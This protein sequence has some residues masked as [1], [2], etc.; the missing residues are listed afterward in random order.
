MEV[1]LNDESL[2]GQYTE[3]EFIEFCKN[4]L[5]PILSELDQYGMTLLKAYS[6]YSKMITSSESVRSILQ[7]RGNPVLDR[8]KCYLVQLT[9]DPFW[10][11]SIKTDLTLKYEGCISDVPN[12]FTEAYARD[13]LLLSFSDERFLEKWLDIICDEKVSKIRNIG[14]YDSCCFHLSELGYIVIWEKNSFF[15]KDIGY[16]FEVRFNEGHHNIAHFHLSN[17][18]E[19]Q[20]LISNSHLE[21]IINAIYLGIINFLQIK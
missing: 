12:C 8:M 4:D 9:K 20:L 13:G 18:D 14:T 19:E 17:A 7:I 3:E 1:L 2:N 11:N 15:I 6:T 21:K 16:K 5:L 10:E